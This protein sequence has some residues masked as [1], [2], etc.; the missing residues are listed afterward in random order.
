[1]FTSST[2]NTL[3]IETTDYEIDQAAISIECMSDEQNSQKKMMLWD[4]V[5]RAKQL[6][7][8]RN[9]LYNGDF[10]DS[11][12]GWTTSDRITIQANNSIFKGHYLN[13]SG[14]RNIDGSI[15]PTYIYQKIE[16][17]KLKPYTR[18]RV[19]GFVGSSKD[20]KL[21][22]TRYGKEIDAMMNVPNDLAYM[23]P[24]PSCGDYRCESSSQYVSHGY[25][26]PTDG[27][28]SDM[29]ACRPN[30]GEK[31]V[32]CHDR[33][34]FDFHIDTGE[35]GTNTNVGIDVLFKISNPDGYA[36]VG[37]LEVIEE[38]P[39]TGE[40]LAH[41]KQK[42]KKW[43]QHME[44]KRWETQQAY[45]PAKQAVDALFTNEQELHYHIT[46]DHIQNA[47]R[48]IQAIPYVYHAWLPNAPGMNYDVYQGL[49]ASIM[50]ARYLYDARNVITNGD[51]TQ[52]LTGWHAA[53]KA[54]VQQ[55]NGASVLVLSN[56]SAGVS[57]NL[58]AQEHHGYVLRVIAKKEG[59][60]KGYVT[61][62]DCNGNQE[63]LKF[64]SCEEGYMTKTV[65]VFPE[66]D[67]VR[68]EIGETEGTFYIDSIELICMKGYTSNNNPRTGNMYEQSYNRNYNQNTSDV[69]HQGYTNNYN[70]DS[71]S[72]YNQNYTNNDDLHSGCTCNQVHNSGCTCN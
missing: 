55:M 68:I 22:V 24:N 58:H 19:R 46:L 27:Y 44:K 47:D 15:F 45:D 35:V 18:Y 48:L 61:M 25:P 13:M 50:Q 28:A 69:Y 62:M 72:M 63:T 7:Q 34:P 17:S 53:G 49:N 65:E 6:S 30:R 38:G 20:L 71:S 23:Q 39:L 41:V 43:N 11:S 56:W 1:M 14:A 29:S 26:T 52:G 67:R 16:E 51:F 54:T 59:P 2:K 33:H 37:N 57:Q 70:Q 40:A 60:G 9:L 66:S 12:N 31:H 3:R 42:E 64:T 10:E 5:K 36:T 8:S 32:M 21:M 4:E